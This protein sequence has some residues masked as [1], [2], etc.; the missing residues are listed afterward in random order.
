DLSEYQFHVF[1]DFREFHDDVEGGWKRLCTELGGRGVENL[2]DEFKLMKYAA[3]NEGFLTATKL[4]QVEEPLSMI[5]YAAVAKAARVFYVKMQRL[6]DDTAD[7]HK[8]DIQVKIIES[9]LKR[10]AALLKM[11]PVSRDAKAF[12]A[13]LS[14]LLSF[15]DNSRLLLTWVLISGMKPGVM[16]QFGLECTLRRMLDRDGARQRIQLL[17]ALLALTEATATET[18]FFSASASREFM[19]VHE[20][21][22]TE[23]FNKERFEDLAEW[24]SVLDFLLPDKLQLATSNLSAVA[25]KAERGLNRSIAL[26]AHAGYRTG[27]FLDL[28]RTPEKSEPAEKLSAKKRI[29]PQKNS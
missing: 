4:M 11:K 22:G 16:E 15:K 3:L 25:A 20:S 17:S 26:A 18:G 9:R 27:L 24:L 6:S 5:D 10:L 14:T 2:E 29:K 8:L 13:R 7:E 23:W 21:S 12:Y 1:V 19:A 28:L